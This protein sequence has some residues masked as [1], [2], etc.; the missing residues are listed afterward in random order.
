MNQAEGI[1]LIAK[2]WVGDP[3][4]R[5]MGHG[6]EPILAGQTTLETGARFDYDV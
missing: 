3:L 6:P 2:Q 1:A 4:G 5:R